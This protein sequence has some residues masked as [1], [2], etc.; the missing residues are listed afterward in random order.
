MIIYHVP[1]K[2]QELVLTYYNNT[3]VRFTTRN[4]TTITLSQEKGI[5]TGC[6]LS[7]SLFLCAFNLLTTA[8][9]KECR[10]PVTRSG[11]RQPS[12]SP[13]MDDITICTEGAAG[14]RP[15]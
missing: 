10:G 14:A 4:Y 12:I 9:E 13:F 3:K 2:V 5:V 8:A 11:V 15:I 1:L 6:T 7:V